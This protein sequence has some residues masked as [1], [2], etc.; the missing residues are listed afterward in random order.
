L[1][2]YR[3]KHRSLDR[4]KTKALRSE[5]SSFM[6]YVRVMLPLVTKDRQG[7]Y[8]MTPLSLKNVEA[9]P[10]D[11]DLKKQCCGKTW[12]ELV[13]AKAEVP[14]YWYQLVQYYKAKCKRDSWNQEKRS[15]DEIEATPQAVMN[16]V[17]REVYRQE[18]PFH[19][20]EVELGKRTH[21]AYRNW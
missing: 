11:N 21:D 5:L 7:W 20:E 14:E 6:E 18:L 1:F 12:R 16:Y 9:A 10:Y 13:S 3:E 2:V 15:Y 19:E 17:A 4:K 8:G